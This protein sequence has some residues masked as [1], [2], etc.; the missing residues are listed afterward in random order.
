MKKK[1]SLIIRLKQK[2]N[3]LKKIKYWL[4]IDELKVIANAD[5]NGILHYNML[6]WTM[7]N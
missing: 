2:I 5:V 3:L 1:K 7:S 4:T 6:L